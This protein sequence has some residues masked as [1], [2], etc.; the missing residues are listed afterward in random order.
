MLRSLV[1]DE[2]FF[3]GLRTHYL[4]Y[5]DGNASTDDFRHTMEDMS[6]RDLRGFFAQWLRRGG[7]PTI[8]TSWSH[9]GGAVTLEVRQTH[10][11]AP[12]SFPLDVALVASDGSRTVTTVEVDAATHA[13][14]IQSESPPASVV[15]DP[16]VKLLARIEMR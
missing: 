11:G 3:E 5:R 4:R 15:L 12:Y 7:V 13:L 10:E 6:G 1:G 14:T 9:G 16:E 2:D 8:E